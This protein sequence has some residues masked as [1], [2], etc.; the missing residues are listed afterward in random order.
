MFQL[1]GFSVFHEKINTKYII[2]QNGMQS[3]SHVPKY[4]KSRF[5][6]LS[7]KIYRKE[8][9]IFR[10]GERCSHSNWPT[11]VFI[12]D[13]HILGYLFVG[14]PELSC[15]SQTRGKGH[16][17]VDSLTQILLGFASGN[18]W[19]VCLFLLDPT[20]HLF[21]MMQACTKYLYILNFC[22]KVFTIYG[23]RKIP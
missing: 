15:H 14:R 16:T 3:Q 17:D 13:T 12:V 1:F 10:L 22:V 8:V 21:L 23:F 4:F 11:F 18:L 2:Q 5:C 9:L 19:A 7:C 20:G 6:H